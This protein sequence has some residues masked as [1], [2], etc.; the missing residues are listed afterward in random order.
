M[1]ADYFTDPND[2]VESHHYPLPSPKDIFT[3]LNGGRIFPQIDFAD[4]YFTCRNRWSVPRATYDQHTRFCM[5]MN[6]CHLE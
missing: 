3:T 1:C 2:V 5:V 6:D 4:A